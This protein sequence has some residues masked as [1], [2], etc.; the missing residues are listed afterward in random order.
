LTVKPRCRSTTRPRLHETAIH[1]TAIHETAPD[2]Q[3][4]HRSTTGTSQENRQ[5]TMTL[6]P[7]VADAGFLFSMID[8]FPQ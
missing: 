3:P 5:T 8:L 1:E 2:P 6:D 7:L 4:E